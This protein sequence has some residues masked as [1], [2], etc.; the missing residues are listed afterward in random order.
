A[1]WCTTLSLS[2]QARSL[3]SRCGELRSLIWWQFLRTSMEGFTPVMLTW[4]SI[5]SS[6]ALATYSMISTSG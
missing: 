1:A 6:N 3:A 4:S 5:L 2:E